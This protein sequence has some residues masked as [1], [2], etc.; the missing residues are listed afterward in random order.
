MR[1][2]DEAGPRLAPALEA[3]PAQGEGLAELEGAVLRQRRLARPVGLD[4]RHLRS[5]GGAVS[6]GPLRVCVRVAV[7]RSV[8]RSAVGIGCLPCG[9]AGVQ[10]PVWSGRANWW[11]G[12]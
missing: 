11:I 5:I 9:D 2:V 1:T 4:E 7:G 10:S 3:Q 6:L 8:D 12:E